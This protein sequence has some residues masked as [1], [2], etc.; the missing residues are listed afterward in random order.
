MS[1]SY[2]NLIDDALGDFHAVEAATAGPVP[3]AG[4]VRATV[5]HRRRVRLGTLSVLAAI[6][7]AIPIAALAA[8]PQG[9]N[10]PPDPAVSDRPSPTAP[11]TP[12]P[13]ASASRSS[14]TPAPPVDGRITLRELGR[15]EVE[16]PPFR[17]SACPDTRVKLP[18]KE[19]G[20][21]YAR[22]VEKVVHTNLDGDSALETAALLLCRAG[23]A[24]DSQVVGFDRDASGKIRTLGL[25]VGQ[26]EM[27]NIRDIGVRP[28][29]GIVADVT[30]MIACCGVP[31][32][33]E[34]R[35]QREYGWDGTRFTQV[36]GATIWGDPRF[37]TDLEVLVSDVVLGPVTDGKRFGS[38]TVTV[39]NN[40]PRA[41]GR[42]QV[43]FGA[44]TF[45]CAA[46]PDW[47]WGDHDTYQPPLEPGRSVR[48]EVEGGFDP[49]T[50]GG[51]ITAMLRVV[52]RSDGNRMDDSDPTND[53]VVFR[54]RIG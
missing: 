3:A 44:C 15:T 40:G 47:A 38:A 34:R 43:G 13:G 37:V 19:S 42:F 20:A 53:T 49:D 7:V 54:V 18:A 23:E 6:V 24:P 9:D 39:R 5:R 50:P 10:P 46:F 16:I 29:G 41:S 17:T 12:T 25:I 8:N 48:V 21:M 14:P 33:R 31:A 26:E 36:G 1:E 4:T 45:D 11:V 35:Q 28:G 22:W 30:D 32:S 51:A 2:D 27:L 52:G